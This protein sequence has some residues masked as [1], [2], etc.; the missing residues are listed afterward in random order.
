MTTWMFQ[1]VKTQLTQV[2]FTIRLLHGSPLHSSK[3]FLV[4]IT[5]QALT[6]PGDHHRWLLTFKTKDGQTL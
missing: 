5:L 1:F 3:T 2:F 4:G 6:D